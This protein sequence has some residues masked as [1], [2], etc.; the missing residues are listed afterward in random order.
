MEVARLLARQS[1]STTQPD[2]G[3]QRALV[4]D[5]LQKVLVLDAKLIGELLPD[6]VDQDRQSANQPVILRESL[7]SPSRRCFRLQET[8]DKRLFSF[9]KREPTSGLVSR[10]HGPGDPIARYAKGGDD[11]AAGAG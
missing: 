10:V 6:L 2:T 11:L 1:R 7:L 8:R 3:A 4:E 5:I 9:D